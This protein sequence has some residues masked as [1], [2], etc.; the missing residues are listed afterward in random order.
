MLSGSG[1]VKSGLT[2][3]AARLEKL[4]ESR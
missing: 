4:K 3:L 1:D 2:A